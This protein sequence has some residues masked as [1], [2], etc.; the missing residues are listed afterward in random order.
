MEAPNI[1][2]SVP[3]PPPK[4]RRFSALFLLGI[5]LVGLFAG[6]LG[7]YFLSYSAFNWK[8]ADLQSQLQNLPSQNAT[9]VNYPNTTYFLDGNVSLSQL[10][11]Q[12]QLSVVQIRG[13]ITQ[14]DIFGRLHYSTVQGS[15]FVTEIDGQAVV[16]TNNHV[17]NGVSSFTVTFTDGNG[18]SAKLLGSDAYADLAVLSIGNASSDLKPLEIVA[19]SSLEVGDPVIAVGSPY[20]LAGSVTSGIVSALGR[21]ITEDLSGGVTIAGVI[22]TSTP[23]NSGNSGGPLVNYA[24]QVVGITTAIVSNSQ[25][26]GFAIP[27]DTILREIRSLVANGSYKQHPSI[28]AAGIDMTFE[29]AQVMNTTVT[30]GWLVESADATTGLKGGAT[31]AIASGTTVT[32][33]GDIVT[34]ING[35]RI[36]NTDDLLTYLEE[37][38][39]PGQTVNLSVVRANQEITM[40]VKLVSLS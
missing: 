29:I 28:N 17:V 25:G 34:A 14:Q 24:G 30:Y 5:L 23:I 16:V 33:G 27:S 11:R 8:I 20:G 18:Y 12:V 6:G 3:L 37:N 38:T 7:G 13:L 36:T 10:Y 15:G 26:L 40:S 35:T 4:A 2:Q 32:I 19:S 9:Y 39:L 21:T 22:Q 1:P 31:Q